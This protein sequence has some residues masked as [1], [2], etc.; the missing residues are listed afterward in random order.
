MRRLFYLVSILTA[1]LWPGIGIFAQSS[2]SVNPTEQTPETAFVS[3]LTYTNAFFGFSF[4]LPRGIPFHQISGSPTEPSQGLLF[5]VESD[6]IRGVFSPRPAV[7][8][9]E[10]RYKQAGDK[11]AEEAR[12]FAEGP[13]KLKATQITIG[14]KEFWKSESTENER[15]GRVHNLTY[16]T[17]L[18]KYV[19]EFVVIS[20]DAK[21][22][23]QLEHSI[24][25]VS[26]FDPTKAAE[27]AGMGSRLYDPS[28]HHIAMLKKGVV[29]AN[30]YT[31]DDLGFTYQ[32]PS[33][34]SVADDATKEKVIEAG[35]QAAWGDSPSAAQEHAAIERCA[36]YLLMVNRYPSGTTTESLN[37]FVALMV[38]DPAC[39]PPDVRFPSSSDDRQQAMVWIKAAFGHITDVPFFGKAQTSVTLSSVEDHVWIDV[40]SSAEV[41]VSD[42]GP[43]LSVFTEFDVTEVRDYWAAWIFMGGSQT[44]LGQLKHTPIT[45]RS[46]SSAPTLP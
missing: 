33:G 27:M 29:W 22:T 6:L 25:S 15:G 42:S 21:L 5:G 36:R 26:F 3:P 9:M 31:N 30:T 13:K 38:L 17:S 11:S 8:A 16:A 2:P 23:G 45:F 37:P 10:I 39:F 4:R 1:I 28:G 20:F 14:G 19:L 12:T 35:H 32:F 43:P 34:W 44:E 40:S 18:G 24:E 7:S 41:N 46:S